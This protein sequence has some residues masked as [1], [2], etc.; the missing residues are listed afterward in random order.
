M[1]TQR[2]TAAYEE[3]PI[4]SRSIQHFSLMLRVKSR[5]W[6]LL[7][8]TANYPVL[9]QRYAF[10]LRRAPAYQEGAVPDSRSSRAR[11]Y[12]SF[13]TTYLVQWRILLSVGIPARNTTA[14]RVTKILVPRDV[15]SSAA[16]PYAWY[17]IR[18]RAIAGCNAVHYARGS[19]P[20]RRHSTDAPHAPPVRPG[21]A[22]QSARMY[23]CMRKERPV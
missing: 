10:T 3:L 20:S 2:W 16:S 13:R 8:W 23:L 15:P 18:R 4:Y 17:I 5:G 1:Q 11:C 19:S 14:H 21:P 6:A 12:G 22:G 7:T 9:L